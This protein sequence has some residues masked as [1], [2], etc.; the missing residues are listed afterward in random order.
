MKMEHVLKATVGGV[1]EKVGVAPGELVE[2]ARVC[3]VVAVAPAEGAK[4]KN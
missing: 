2:D 4:K 3:M 1:V